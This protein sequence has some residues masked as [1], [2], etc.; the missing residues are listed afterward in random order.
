MRRP[1]W[2]RLPSWLQ[3]RPKVEVEL[4]VYVNS[5]YLD[6]VTALSGRRPEVEVRESDLVKPGEMVLIKADALRHF[7]SDPINVYPTMSPRS[8]E[9]FSFGSSP[10]VRPP[11]SL[12][13]LTIP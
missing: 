6:A 10:V 1:S 13:D 8:I 4:Y 7:E 2:L 3:R 12:K 5:L 9:S 11:S